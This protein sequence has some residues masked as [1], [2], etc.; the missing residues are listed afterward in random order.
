M[1]LIFLLLAGMASWAV[2][3]FLLWLLWQRRGV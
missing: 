1:R 3:I 2:V